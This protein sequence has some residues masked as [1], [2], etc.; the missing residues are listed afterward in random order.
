[1]AKSEVRELI[2]HYFLRKKTIT[3]TKPKLDKY[4]G[5]FAPSISMVN[6]WFTEFRSGR[7]NT[8]DAERSGRPVEVAKQLKKFA[9]WCWPIGN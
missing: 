4:Y 3:E 7:T 1:M 2:K 8:I 9:I 5:D 6:K